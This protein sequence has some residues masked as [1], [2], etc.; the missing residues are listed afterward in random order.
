MMEILKFEIPLV[1]NFTLELPPNS[2]VL[3]VQIQRNVP[4]IW[5][6]GNYEQPWTTRKFTL[7]VT[8]MKYDSNFTMS[9]NP[10]FENG[11]ER[12]IG[13]FQLNDGNFVGHLFEIM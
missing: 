7:R 6:M 10:R 13:T 5:V 1:G 3:S 2:T 12:Y 4:V 9:P 11:L 8:G